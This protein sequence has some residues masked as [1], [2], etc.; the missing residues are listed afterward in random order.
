M[1][2]GKVRNGTIVKFVP[3]KNGV[4]CHGMVYV[5]YNRPT[6]NPRVVQRHGKVV[7]RLYQE[8]LINEHGGPP[9]LM[10]LYSAFGH[11]YPQHLLTPTEHSTPAPNL[12][13][14]SPFS[15]FFPP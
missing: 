7:K 10:D 5:L 4:M 1:Y 6:M 9:P 14:Y 12:N 15:D 2:Y 8:L 3:S 13:V 11:A